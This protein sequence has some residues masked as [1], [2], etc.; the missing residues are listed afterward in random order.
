MA[1]QQ[2]KCNQP[3]AAACR[4]GTWRACGGPRSSTLAPF[5]QP[6]IAQDVAILVAVDGPHE[7]LVD[8]GLHGDDH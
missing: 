5:V 3:C 7:L 8:A 6:G 4:A 1:D 2:G